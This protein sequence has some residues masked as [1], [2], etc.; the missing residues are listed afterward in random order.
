[1]AHVQHRPPWTLG[2]VCR[3]WRSSALSLPH[4]WT[5]FDLDLDSNL[6]FEHP[7]YRGDMQML[8]VQLE[9]CDGQPIH[10]RLG[11]P[12]DEFDTSVAYQILSTV[13]S[14]STRVA[15]LSLRIDSCMFDCLE[16]HFMAR[17]FPDLQEINLNNEAER[18]L[19]DRL[20]PVAF[21]IA[22]R[23]RSLNIWGHNNLKRL[24]VSWA[25]ITRYI[26]RDSEEFYAETACITRFSPIRESADVLVGLC[27]A[28]VEDDRHATPGFMQL[29]DSITLPALRI[30]KF[31]NSTRESS[32]SLDRFVRR[33]GCSLRVLTIYEISF[34]DER[35]VFSLL[36]SG[37]LKALEFLSLGMG[38]DRDY[39]RKALILNGLTRDPAQEDH[40]PQLRVS[41]TNC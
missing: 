27:A 20:G 35:D 5:N 31:S 19:A 2:K 23:L 10:A 34:H 32:Q 9:R 36:T 11:D 17:P 30:L 12:P 28:P 38:S 40:F 15:S 24:E 6:S 33:S 41:E 22:P 29:F 13:L 14:T 37:S 26:S 1:M 3:A 4:L 8:V 25:Q 39:E 7:I 18:S 21:Q 16:K